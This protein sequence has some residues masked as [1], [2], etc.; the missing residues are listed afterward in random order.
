MTHF[1][2]TFSVLL[3]LALLLCACQPLV[4]PGEMAPAEEASVVSAPAPAL[5]PALVAEIEAL[6]AQAMEQGQIPGAA[7]GIVENGELVYAN[8]FG[9]A[10]LASDTPVTPQTLFQIASVSKTAVAAAVLQLVERGLMDLD[11]PVTDY[12]PYFT[13][14][15]PESRN[16][17]IRQ[18]LTHTA[19]M[20]DVASWIAEVRDQEL[21]TDDMALEDY[22]RSL[23][24]ESLLFLPGEA[25][26]YSSIG[27]D[28]LGDVIAKASGQ[29]FE[30]YML[31]SILIPLGMD[32]SSFLLSE[33]NPDLLAEP[34]TYDEDGVVMATGY[35]PYARRHGPASAL[36]TNVEDLARYANALLQH[37]DVEGTQ[38]FSASAIDEMWTPYTETGWAEWF[39]PT[40]E[41]YG[42]GWLLGEV[43]GHLVPNHTGGMDDGYQAHLLLV[44]DEGFAVIALVNIFDRDEGSFHAYGIADEVMKVL[45]GMKG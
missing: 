41:S 43:D 28:V 38:V 9:M 26:M 23:S 7:I 21:R 44:P 29:S 14:A 3:A 22:I 24:D 6:V 16:M 27:Y 33:E 12:L 40:W 1:M 35:Y 11:A 39:G 25:F 30:E 34:Y 10:D 17:T 32:N 37:G 45:L 42:L 18:L 5:D 19:G 8:G 20:P 15:E 36:W 31:E 4:A 2:R 13:L